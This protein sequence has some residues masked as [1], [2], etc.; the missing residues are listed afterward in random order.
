MYNLL[1]V[2]FFVSIV[3]LFVFGFHTH[4]PSLWGIQKSEQGSVFVIT[5]CDHR[6]Y[7]ERMPLVAA[8][9]CGEPNDV[10]A[11]GA[12]YVLWAPQKIKPGLIQQLINGAKEYGG[13]HGVK[14][15]AKF[16]ENPK[17]VNALDIALVSVVGVVV[18]QK[19]STAVVAP[20]CEQ[21]HC[22][23]YPAG[24]LTWYGNPIWR[25]EI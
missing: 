20:D 18:D 6:K 22:Y 8:S 5:N 3:C 14:Y 11:S 25:F 7:Y 10:V 2:L 9:S 24:F 1:S 4:E 21:G 16:Q 13:S 12:K 15:D 17:R 23:S 19:N